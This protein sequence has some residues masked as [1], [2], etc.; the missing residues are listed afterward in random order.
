MQSWKLSLS[1]SD[2]KALLFGP[3]DSLGEFGERGAAK[4]KGPFTTEK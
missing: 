4:G 2:F 1:P 3:L